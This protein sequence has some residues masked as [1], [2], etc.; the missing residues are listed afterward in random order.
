MFV[1]LLSPSQKA[2]R[3]RKMCSVSLEENTS[4]WISLL[5]LYVLSKALVCYSIYM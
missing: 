4:I 1:R 3:C 5:Y 2:W